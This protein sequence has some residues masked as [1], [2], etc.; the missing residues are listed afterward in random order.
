MLFECR[1]EV[2]ASQG[3]NLPVL[4]EAGQEEEQEVNKNTKKI[5]GEYRRY[6][7]TC[8]GEVKIDPLSFRSW[9]R[10]NFSKSH[11]ESPKMLAVL[12]A[13]P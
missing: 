8:K 3:G 6:V 4:Q 9:V 13:R 12:K 10:A 5:H 1:G 11:R 2:R 7:A